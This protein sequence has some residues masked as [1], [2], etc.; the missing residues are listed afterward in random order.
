M[1]I[2]TMIRF[3]ACLLYLNQHNEVIGIDYS[4][5]FSYI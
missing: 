2:E 1:V 3:Q 5:A 4:K